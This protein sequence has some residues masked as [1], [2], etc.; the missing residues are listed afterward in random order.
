MKEKYAFDAR[1]ES[2]LLVEN[3]NDLSIKSS[4]SGMVVVKMK[5][6]GK[7]FYVRITGEEKSTDGEDNYQFDQITNDL[8]NEIDH[9]VPIELYKYEIHTTRTDFNLEGLLNKDEYYNGNNLADITKYINISLFMHYIGDIHFNSIDFNSI[10]DITENICLMLNSYSSESNY[11]KSIE[12]TS[13]I[14]LFSP[15]IYFEAGGDYIE[16]TMSF[17]QKEKQYFK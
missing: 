8:I 9:L 3:T 6:N 15:K 5:A 7:K 2:V 16:S 12:L 17:F 4:S 14:S 10:S 11:E 13:K 1:V